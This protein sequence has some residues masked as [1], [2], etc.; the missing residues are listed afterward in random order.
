MSTC[1]VASSTERGKVLRLASELLQGRWLWRRIGGTMRI[2]RGGGCAGDDVARGLRGVKGEEGEEEVAVVEVTRTIT[3]RGCS[4]WTIIG[5]IWSGAE[6]WVAIW[7]TSLRRPLR[8]NAKSG[9][10]RG[11][12]G[13]RRLSRSCFA[14]SG[15]KAVV[16][17]CIFCKCYMS[18]CK[19]LL[20]HRVE[21]RWNMYL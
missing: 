2:V 1:T 15:A 7:G 6:W 11:A 8:R 19:C 5:P 10:T 20:L 4:R 21:G 9:N 18:V 13:R 16:V 17:L 12:S 3:G 14:A